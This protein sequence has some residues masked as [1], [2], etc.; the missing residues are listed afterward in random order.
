VWKMPSLERRP[1]AKVQLD[2]CP[3]QLPLERLEQGFGGARHCRYATSW[4]AP[5]SIPTTDALRAPMPAPRF[6]AFGYC[7]V[8]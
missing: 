1:R 5:F 3:A 4:S 2:A 6:H 7:L 8:T